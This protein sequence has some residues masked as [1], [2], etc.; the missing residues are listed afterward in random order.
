MIN[1]T[2]IVSI[3]VCILSGCASV[4][5]PAKY[6]ELGF[7]FTLH[8][9]LPQEEKEYESLFKSY[10][11]DYF[12]IELEESGIKSAKLGD[13]PPEMAFAVHWAR[14]HSK[15]MSG[16]DCNMDTKSTDENTVKEREEATKRVIAF[17]LAKTLR[18]VNKASVA[19]QG[20]ELSSINFDQQKM[21]KRQ[22]CMANNIKKLS[23]NSR[24]VLVITGAYHSNFFRREFPDAKFPLETD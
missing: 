14:K 10:N 15:G 5:K 3:L 20:A 17:Y 2:V 6:P 12:L 13:F 16:F 22:N 1:R 8:T 11:P 21:A 7:V 18:D 24:K 4:P 9:L 19:K 23:A